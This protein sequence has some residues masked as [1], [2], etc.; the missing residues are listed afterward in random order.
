VRSR[1]AW[2]THWTAVAL[3]EAVGI[4]GAW[5]G[6]D[7]GQARENLLADEGFAG[8]HAEAARIAAIVDAQAEGRTDPDWD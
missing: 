2:S 7:T 3:D 1:L 6:C 5:Q 8:Q 4:R